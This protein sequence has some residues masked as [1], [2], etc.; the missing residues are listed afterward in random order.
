MKK[1]LLTLILVTPAYAEDS[2]SL[3]YKSDE[4]LVYSS[5]VTHEDASLSLHA[6]LFSDAHN[7]AFWLNDV[8]V[9]SESIPDH[10]HVLDVT[11][12]KVKLVYQQGEIKN[13][14]TLKPSQTVSLKA[15]N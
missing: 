8:K 5:D 13:T 12:E 10:I 4:P 2:F 14:Y 3:F 1:A 9:S 6:I 15:S 11:A 7:W